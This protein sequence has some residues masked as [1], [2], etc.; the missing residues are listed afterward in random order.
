ME[1]KNGQGGGERMNKET[2]EEKLDNIAQYVCENLCKIP[3]N[4][5]YTQDTV[6]GFCEKCKLSEF[7]KDFKEEKEK[8]SREIDELYLEKCREV[9]SLTASCAEFMEGKNTNIRIGV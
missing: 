3:V 4:P 6:D 1:E 7:I 2:A 8:F 9:N 5:T